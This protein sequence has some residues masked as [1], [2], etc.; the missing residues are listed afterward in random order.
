MSPLDADMHFLRL[1]VQY[2]TAARSAVLAQLSIDV[3]GNLYHHATEMLLKARLSQKRSLEELSRPPFGHKLYALWNAFKAEF[4]TVGLDQFDDT[5]ATL[6]RFERLRY[7]DAIIKEGAEMIVM[8]EPISSTYGPEITPPSR[9]QIIVTEIDRLVA[10]IFEV[11]SRNPAFFTGRM[12]EYAREAITRDNPACGS[13]FP[14]LT[15]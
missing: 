15:S 1:G 4:P 13:W 7:P 11:S 14:K 10:R 3:S 2:Y 9:Y 8:W 12:N 6:D 5:I